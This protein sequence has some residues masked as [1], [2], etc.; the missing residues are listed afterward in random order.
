MLARLQVCKH[1]KH[2]VK[3]ADVVLMGGVMMT[4]TR[5]QLGVTVNRHIRC[6]MR[7]SLHQAHADDIGRIFVAW[8]GAA[9]IL[10]CVLDALRDDGRGVKQGAIPVKGDQV[11]LAGHFSSQVR[12]GL[13]G[14]RMLRVQWVIGPTIQSARRC[15]DD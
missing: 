10:N 15:P 4:V 8:P 3:E 2:P 12:L 9:Y 1:A 11:K 6:G 7:Q 13:H 5:S 14:S